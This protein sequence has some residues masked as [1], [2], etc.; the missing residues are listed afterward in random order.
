MGIALQATFAAP[1]PALPRA[2]ELAALGAVLCL[3]RARPGSELSGWAQAARAEVA[4]GC[5][6]NGPCEALW[7]F[8]HDGR[9]CWRLYLLPDSD[10]LAWDSPAARLPVHHQP[11]TG[12]VGERLWTRLAGCL[13]GERWHAVPLRL[14]ARS[15][16]PGFSR[17]GDTGL[18]A[19]WPV[20]S[21]AGQAAARRIAR[22]EG[23]EGDTL[24]DAIARPYPMIHP[25]RRHP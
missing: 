23:V 9:C 10:F 25:T 16:G 3:S 15:G 11:R 14:H 19:T 1:L 18:S 6:S 12:G 4:S 5:D 2:G 7:M 24:D 21:A 17:C 8:D 22:I 20:L 13:R